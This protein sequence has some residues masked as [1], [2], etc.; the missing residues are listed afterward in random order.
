M[1]PVLIEREGKVDAILMT[2]D[3]YRTLK[4]KADRADKLVDGRPTSRN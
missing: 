2:M 1:R 4:E 3:L